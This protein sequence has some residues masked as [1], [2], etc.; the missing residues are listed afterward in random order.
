MYALQ[1]SGQ[2]AG[3]ARW[4]LERMKKARPSISTLYW[5]G[6]DV[7]IPHLLVPRFVEWDDVSDDARLLEFVR[8]RRPPAKSDVCY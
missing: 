1:P 6:G 4:A 5:G 7:R 3:F 2:L 8:M